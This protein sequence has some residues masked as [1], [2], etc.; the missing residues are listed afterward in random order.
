M[1]K[2]QTNIKNTVETYKNDSDIKIKSQSQLTQTIFHDNVELMV[3]G[4]ILINKSELTI[5]SNTKYFLL[6]HNGCGKTTLLNHIYSKL[7]DTTDI[8]LIEQDIKITSEQNIY[9]F[10]LD[11]NKIL[12]D[13]YTEYEKLELIE[14]PSDEQFDNITQI[15]EYLTQNNWYTYQ[16]DAKKNFRWSRIYRLGKFC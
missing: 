2:Q 4:K 10:I 1:V 6:G 7:K 14:N 16:A 8:L 3:N 5:N 9:D 15:Q 12:H 13:T 11:A